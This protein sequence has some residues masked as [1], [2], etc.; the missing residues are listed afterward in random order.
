VSTN[1]TLAEVCRMMF[2][3]ERTTI[4][5]P[6]HI[7]SHRPFQSIRVSTGTLRT[8]LRSTFDVHETHFSPFDRFDGLLSS[9]AWFVCRRA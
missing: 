5:R 3:T 7:N 8:E 1:Y 6:V 4:S 2:A 9:Q